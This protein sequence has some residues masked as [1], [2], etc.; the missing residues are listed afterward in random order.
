MPETWKLEEKGYIFVELPGDPAPPPVKLDL[1]R[2]A[3]SVLAI[4]K[5]NENP[6]PNANQAEVTRQTTDQLSD[7]FMSIGFPDMPHQMVDEL[8][9]KLLDTTNEI[10]KKGQPGALN[11]PSPDSASSTG[12]TP[13]N[14]APTPS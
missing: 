6:D 10:K 9:T 1:Y 12:S 8:A 3:N 7:F 5:K 13:T 2:T 4:I 11:T 14:A